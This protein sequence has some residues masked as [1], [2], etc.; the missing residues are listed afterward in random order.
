MAIREKIYNPRHPHWCR[1]YR[2]ANVS[3][4]EDDGG[5]EI[6]YE[7]PC[8]E[9]SNNSIRTFNTHTDAGQILNGDYALSIP[10]TDLKVRAGDL[11]D[12]KS[13]NFDFVGRQCSDCYVG[14]LGSI[15]YFNYSKN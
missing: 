5:A 14:T 1:I 3:S 10:R 2:Y 8:R 11:I 7:G 13:K 12:C 6:L 9:C 15:V 4:F